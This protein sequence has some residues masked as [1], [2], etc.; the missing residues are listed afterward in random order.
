MNKCMFVGGTVSALNSMLFILIFGLEE[1]IVK[2][3]G[4]S[5]ER[6]HMPQWVCHLGSRKMV[7]DLSKSC[8]LGLGSS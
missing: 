5:H 2:G 3:I 1:I 6:F 7:K 4:V 8:T